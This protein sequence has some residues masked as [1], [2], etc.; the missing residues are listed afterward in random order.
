MH[1]FSDL[2]V[3]EAGRIAAAVAGPVMQV[4]RVR[5]HRGIEQFS[6]EIA[7]AG[8][9]GG[10]AGTFLFRQPTP[11]DM[12]FTYLPPD[13]T[14]PLFVRGDMVGEYHAQLL[15][16]Q[17]SWEGPVYAK[18]YRETV[19]EPGPA[20]LTEEE[21]RCLF[22][23]TEL[24]NALECMAYPAVSDDGV[25]QLIASCGLDPE[26]LDGISCMIFSCMWEMHRQQ[27]YELPE[28]A[29]AEVQRARRDFAQEAFRQAMTV[30]YHVPGAWDILS[31]VVPD[32]EG[33]FR[34]V[35]ACRA[36]KRP[37]E[38]EAPWEE[39]KT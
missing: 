5:H 25:R 16:L 34:R 8:P 10:R 37:P 13:G 33:F 12:G 1:R 32:P 29:W 19:S 30:L 11:Y 17:V 9:S 14:G 24:G 27:R 22:R 39:E 35:E 28:D 15:A 4:T 2:S 21:L 38:A 26:A 36:V 31:R 7:S 18:G 23:C 20:G 6:A 3:E